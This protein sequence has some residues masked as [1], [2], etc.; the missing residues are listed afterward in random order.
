MKTTAHT[1]IQ[2]QHPIRWP[3]CVQKTCRGFVG[4]AENV[5]RLRRA[6]RKRAEASSGVQKTCRGFVGRAENA[7]CVQSL[8]CAIISGSKWRMIAVACARMSSFASV[9]STSSTLGTSSS[10]NTSTKGLQTAAPDS[11]DMRARKL[12]PAP[13]QPQSGQRR[14]FATDGCNG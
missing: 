6:C 4:R 10:T 8:H 12:S 11:A 13:A 9:N 2:K 5:R 1:L 7:P 3:V 14:D